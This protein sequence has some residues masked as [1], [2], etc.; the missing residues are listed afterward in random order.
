MEEQKKNPEL[1]FE[2][3]TEDWNEEVLGL[4]AEFTKGQGYSKNDLRATGSPIIL[5][6]RLYTKYQTV[7]DVVDT[8]TEAQE[9]SYYSSG[10]EVIV[11]A[12][13]ETQEDIIRASVVTKSNIILGGDL[14]IVK[15]N[16]SIDSN[17]L[18]LTISNGRVYRDLVKRAQGKSV[19]HIRNGDL[20][21][22]TIPYPRKIEQQQIGSFF[23]NIDEL[24][25]KHQKKHNR[26]V[27]LKK[28]MLEKM[29][30]REGQT[31]PEIRFKGFE[32]DWSKVEL[33]EVGEFFRGREIGKKDIDSK[34]KYPCIL[35]GHLYTDYGMLIEKVKY[36]T[37]KDFEGKVTSCLGDV[38][39]PCSDTTPT[40]L[41]RATSVEVEGVI[42]GGD[43]NVIRPNKTC[44]GS[45]LSININANRNKL[46]PLI[47]G[48][49]VRHLD[50]SDLKTVQLFIPIDIDEQM[51]IVNYFKKIEL[52]TSSHEK[53]LQKLQNLKQS[54]TEKM[55]V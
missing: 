20:K 34:G 4:L 9:N 54:L 31:V 11:P 1:R 16:E 45:F 47:K 36:S 41:A 46:I 48:S 26:L 13:G 12:S 42:L 43:I 21:E 38:L 17:F 50:N 6:G 19:V 55:F 5:Y 18:A 27:T 14:N 8:Y 28:S 52:L 40:G 15:P 37:N 39:I 10:G 7:I 51:Q 35:Y 24:I 25:T 2:G 23:K 30:P 32:G 22:V 3:F 49:T 44:N 53:Q 29:F 33:D